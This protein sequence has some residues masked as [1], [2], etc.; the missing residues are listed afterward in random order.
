MCSPTVKKEKEEGRKKRFLCAMGIVI[1]QSGASVWKYISIGHESSGAEVIFKQ[2]LDI[3]RINLGFVFNH[4][5]Y[6]LV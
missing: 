3:A 1:L 2:Y 4:M 6:N 5:W